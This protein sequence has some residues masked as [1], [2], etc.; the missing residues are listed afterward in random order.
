MVQ[1]GYNPQSAI[2]WAEGDL[3]AVLSSLDHRASSAQD[4]SLLKLLPDAFTL[5]ILWDTCS[6]G[7]TA[8][9]WRLQDL[10]LPSGNLPFSFLA[11]EALAL[12]G[13]GRT[14]RVNLGILPPQSSLLWIYTPQL[15][16]FPPCTGPLRA[17]S[18]NLPSSP[19][20][21]PPS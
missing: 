13:P 3:A 5:T 16:H 19:L 1:L 8:V 4:V 10:F 6:R 15:P 18:W 9:C 2:P 11:C 7:A 14:L 21:L 20:C 12:S 17:N